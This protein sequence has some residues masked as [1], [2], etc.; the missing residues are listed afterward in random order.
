MLECPICFNNINDN[1]KCITDCN[2]IYCKDC[3][4]NWFE[5]NKVDCPICRKK[6]IYYNNNNEN[7]RLLLFTNTKIINNTNNIINTN[8][9]SI[10]KKK[11]ILLNINLL[12][13]FIFLS[14]TTYLIV[15][16]C[17]LLN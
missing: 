2:H 3:L 6:I 8:T 1:N 11:Y 14:S 10:H 9:V 15:T 7:Y 16:N 12:F 4:N 5:K 13:S 17:E